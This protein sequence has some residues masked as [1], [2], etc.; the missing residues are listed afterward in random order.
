MQQD[1][2]MTTHK[3]P[4]L[5]TQRK[6][7]TITIQWWDVALNLVSHKSDLYGCHESTFDIWYNELELKKRN[8]WMAHS[9]FFFK[10]DWRRSFWYT[11]RLPKKST[12]CSGNAKWPIPNRTALN[13]TTQWKGIKKT[14]VN[15]IW[16]QLGKQVEKHFYKPLHPLAFVAARLIQS[17]PFRT[18][19]SD[20]NLLAVSF[21]QGSATLVLLSPAQ[22]VLQAPSCLIRQPPACQHSRSPGLSPV[23]LHLNLHLHLFNGPE[24]SLRQTAQI[25]TAI[26]SLSPTPQVIKHNL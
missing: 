8:M 2:R 25:H 3:A 5:N 21:P 9:A 19:L 20:P 1:N 17:L 16:K 6:H 14:H 10:Q 18:S 24:L 22:P 15:T 12:I 23:P 26:R 13:H 4:F 7:S 11:P